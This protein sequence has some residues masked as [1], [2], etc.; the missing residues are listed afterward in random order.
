MDGLEAVRTMIHIENIEKKYRNYRSLNGISLDI[1]EGE[2]FGL[3]GENGAGK[4][5]LVSILATVLKPSAGNVRMNGLDL[6]KQKRQIRQMIGFVPQE[7]A[8]WEDFTVKENFYFWSKFVKEKPSE[9]KLLGL[10]EAVSLKDKWDEKVSNLS[11][12][13]KRKLNIAVALIHD[14]AILLMDE[15][16]VGIDLQSKLEINQ[17]MKRMAQQ[18]KT[19]V[20]IT[21]DIHEIIHLCDRIGVLRKG[22]LQF[23]GTLEEARENL[24]KAERQ[25]MRIEDV[26]YHLLK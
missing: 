15:P 9:E 1:Q 22:I 23:V 13:M 19:I 12:G 18:G 21:H 26:V 16:T 17:Y 4:S 8:L 14:P 7:I 20:Y 3:L 24:G 6:R 25:E 11:G 10:C 5:T 2:I